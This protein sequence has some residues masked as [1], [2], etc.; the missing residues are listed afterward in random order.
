MGDGRSLSEIKRLFHENKEKSSKSAKGGG[1]PICKLISLKRRVQKF[2]P[3]P[4]RERKIHNNEIKVKGATV[5]KYLSFLLNNIKNKIYA[6]FPKL[7]SFRHPSP[8]LIF[9]L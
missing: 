9:R 7:S 5:K 1:R 8:I 6:T 2:L 4:F 3:S